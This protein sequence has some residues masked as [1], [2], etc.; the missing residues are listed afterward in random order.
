MSEDYTKDFKFAA[1]AFVA[2]VIVL[3]H[4]AWIMRQLVISRDI[5]TERLVFYFS[6]LVLT[7]AIVLLVLAKVVY[8]LVYI[9]GET[10][11]QKEKKEQ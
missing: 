5:S 9:D 4:Y 10:K 11:E 3:V 6:L 2:L 7:I 8:P 1:F